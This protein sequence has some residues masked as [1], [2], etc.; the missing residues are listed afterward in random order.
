MAK[1]T[2]LIGYG[3]SFDMK[4]VGGVKTAD[5]FERAAKSVRKSINRSTDATKQHKLQLEVLDQSLKK[6]IV[7][8][9]QYDEARF[10]VEAKEI[11]R[12]QRLEKE[13]RL[14]LGLDQQ[15]SLLA[16]NRQQ[17]ARMAGMAASGVSGLGMG[18]AAAGAAR[19]LG[20]TVGLGLGAAGMGLGFVGAATVKAS[21]SAFAKLESQV[22]AMKSL[23][24]EDIAGNLNTQFRALAKTTILTN[25]QLIE[26]AKTW[27]SYGLTTEGL[28]DRLK[29]LGT[30]AGGNSEKFRALTIAFAQVNAQGKLMGQ[31][32]NQLIN[33]G[34]SLSAVADAAGISM[35]QFADAMKNGEITAEHLNQALVNVTSEGGLFAGYLEKQ[36]ETVT[37]KMTILSASWEEFLVA[38]GE[39][40]QGPA[41]VI[42]D[43]MIDAAVELKAAAEWWSGK[44]SPPTPG[45]AGAQ[46]SRFAGGIVDTGG[47]QATYGARGGFM[48]GMGGGLQP[49][50]NSESER[51]RTAR[52]ER[53]RALAEE[54]EATKKRE[55]AEKQ[56]NDLLKKQFKQYM[57]N[58]RAAEG[59]IDRTGKSFA[60]PGQPTRLERT[61]TSVISDIEQQGLF[62]EAERIGEVFGESAMNQFKQFFPEVFSETFKDTFVGPMPKSQYDL[63]KEQSEEERKAR[64]HRESEEA[65]IRQFEVDVLK[66]EQGLLDDKFKNEEQLIK[67]E[68][69]RKKRMA[70]SPSF[71]SFEGGSVAEFMFL[72]SRSEQNE[73]AKA[74]R[75]AEDQAK[76]QRQELA[77]KK[78]A[79]DLNLESRIVEL[80]SIIQGT[81]VG[82]LRGEN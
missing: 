60:I 6:S 18:G 41:S 34:M 52:E 73:T 51:E 78:E 80:I 19:F 79:Q 20:G 37:G 38:L 75:E 7:T 43:K 12:Q 4:L 55:A 65:R 23:F 70:K 36:A 16:K 50:V 44:G 17:R 15:E 5:D 31:E 32:K 29:R 3:I 10:S 1:T 72:K 58:L 81:F 35:D 48:G 56:V 8:Q 63:A 71:Q 47:A 13:R 64:E 69:D 67:D 61:G 28:T 49:S 68:L 9:K 25:S 59:F 54:E 40:E 39:S 62:E 26:N 57:D 22:T 45:V 66:R 2:K 30:V 11:K 24:G 46:A 33:A 74:I 77:A 76:I 82:P 27:A 53:L 21:I 14:V 42:L